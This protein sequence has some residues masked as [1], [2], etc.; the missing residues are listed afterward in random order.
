MVNFWPNFLEGMSHARH[1]WKANNHADRTD[2]VDGWDS[3]LVK[4]LQ[5]SLHPYLLQD[6]GVLAENPGPPHGHEKGMAEWPYQLPTVLAGQ[7]VERKVEVFNGGLNGSTLT[8]RWT[9]HWDSPTGLEAVK[10]GEIPCEIEPGFHTTTTIAFTAPKI[11]QDTRKLYLVLES[12]LAGQIVFR[13]EETC[14]NVITRKVEPA[15]TFL[16]GDQT[17]TASGSDGYELIGHE[18]KLPPYAKLNWLKGAVWIFDKATDDPRALAYFANPPTGKDRIAACRYGEEVAFT[19]DAGPTPRRLTLYCVDYDTKSRKQTVELLDAITGR[20]LD[21]QVIEKFF[22]GRYL[23]WKIQGG[24]KV[25]VRKLAG[26]NA[27]ISGIF[28][29]PAGK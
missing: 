15:A 29:D 5:R 26:N 10:G 14:L 23:S 6:L 12:S 27:V 21:K 19:L 18:S 20:S 4:F 9:A 25:N 17:H 11:A 8:L 2:G 16:G 22:K 13:S 28:L 1:P 7:P 24:V 3:P